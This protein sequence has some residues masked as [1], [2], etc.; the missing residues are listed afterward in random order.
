MFFA[1]QRQ[2]LFDWLSFLFTGSAKF[3]SALAQFCLLNLMLNILKSAATQKSCTTSLCFGRVAKRS[4]NDKLKENKNDVSR[5]HLHH[6]KNLIMTEFYF[7]NGQLAIDLQ[8]WCAGEK[9]ITE[10]FA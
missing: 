2:L 6:L 9:S 10:F 1:V 4:T 3:S 7:L 8:S 5:F